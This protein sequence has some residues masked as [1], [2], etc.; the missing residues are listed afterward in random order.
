MQRTRFAFG[1]HIT[2]VVEVLISVQ[3]RTI[4]PDRPIPSMLVCV[5]CVTCF[6]G[7][8][9]LLCSGRRSSE[10]RRNRVIS[11]SFRYEEQTHFPSTSKLHHLT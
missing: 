7:S 11:D 10:R 1:S 4:Q 6:G 8:L 9:T 5:T 2:F 3:R